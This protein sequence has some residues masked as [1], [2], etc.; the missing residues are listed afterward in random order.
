MLYPPEMY[1]TTKNNDLILKYH[2]KIDFISDTS[3]FKL[4]ALLQ[5]WSGNMLKTS[6]LFKIISDKLLKEHVIISYYYEKYWLRQLTQASY[7]T[8]PRCF[9]SERH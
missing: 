5:Y 4:Y 9:Y 1:I 7:T 3:K 2:I 6:L 8:W